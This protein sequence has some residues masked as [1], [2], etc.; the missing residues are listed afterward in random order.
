MERYVT[1]DVLPIIKYIDR[2][3]EKAIIPEIATAI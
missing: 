1:G 3:T 2:L